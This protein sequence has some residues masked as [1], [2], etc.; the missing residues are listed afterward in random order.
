L[1]QWQL[2][3]N[4]YDVDSDGRISLAELRRII[5]SDSY[6]K[7]IPE[8][9]VKQILKRADEDANG[10]IEYPEFLKMVCNGFMECFTLQCPSGQ[11]VLL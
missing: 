7:D 5:R 1:Q 3:F 2:I 10:Y 4:K 9:T 6:T 8:H 11:Q